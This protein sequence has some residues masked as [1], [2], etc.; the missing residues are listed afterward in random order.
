M[1]ML[2]AKILLAVDGSEEAESAARA[3]IELSEKTGSELHVIY[4]APVPGIF[5]V[6]V[7]EAPEQLREIAEREG[8]K[9]LDDQLEKIRGMGGEVTEAHLEAGTPDA[10][11]VRLGEEIGAGLLVVGSRGVGSLRRTLMGSVSEST[12]HHAHCPVLVARWREEGDAGILG[13]RILVAVDGSEESG[14]AVEAATELAVSTGAEL[15]VVHALPTEPSMPYPYPYA[16]ERW[17]A[18]MEQA[19]KDARA[20]VEKRAGQVEAE[21]GVVARAHLRLGRPDREIVRLS[22]ELDA[23]MLVLGSRGLGGVKRALMGSVSDSVVRHAHSSV[24]VVRQ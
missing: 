8:R 11:I 19:K 12:V 10:E 9:T 15:H 6:Y 13:S 5:Y 23:G 17:E 21:T 3:G 24:L 14:M 18:S 20:F 16:K 4:V 22:E 7:P 2:P 1:S